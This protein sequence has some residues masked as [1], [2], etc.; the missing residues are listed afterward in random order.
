[1]EATL[2]LDGRR[3]PCGT[4]RR[5][6]NRYPEGGYGLHS[7]QAD[8]T[9]FGAYMSVCESPPSIP[10]IRPLYRTR[11]HPMLPPH[12]NGGTTKRFKNKFDYEYK[13]PF[14]DENN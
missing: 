9:R 7:R 12:I 1:M 5:P 14:D 4:G 10:E 3:P 13:K 2:P 6:D 11:R 8:C